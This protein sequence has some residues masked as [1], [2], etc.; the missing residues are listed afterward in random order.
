MNIQQVLPLFKRAEEI[1]ELSKVLGFYL[2]GLGIQSYAFTYYDL[3]PSSQRPIR[4][5][6]V[7]PALDIWHQHFI[8]SQYEDVDQ[9]LKF[10]KKR[11]EPIFW[12]VHEQV[13]DT[14]HPKE[15]RL[16]KES[17]EYGINKGVLIPIHGPEDDF[18]TLVLHQR[19]EETW[20]EEHPEYVQEAF[21]AGYYY[22]GRLVE[23]LPSHPKANKFKLTKREIQC[24]ELCA[25]GYLAREIAKVL[26][27][28]ERT[29][30][31]HIQNLNK[32]MG[33]NNKYQAIL[34]AQKEGIIK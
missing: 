20:L 12:D 1:K 16:R 9:T 27:I 24:L 32:K 31:Y 21:L 4:Y 8:A 5:S 3:Y 23:I 18:S 26:H 29:A 15:A 28:T 7:S 13:K 22:Y 33:V 30:N 17:I 2:G 6:Y 10:A 14:Q 34:R 25:K 11:I 19:A